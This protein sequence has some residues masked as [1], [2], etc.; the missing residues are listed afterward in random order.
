[1][2]ILVTGGTGF[3]GSHT[4]VELQ[5]KGYEVIIV[6]N[7]SNSSADIADKIGEIS[8]VVPVLEVFDLTDKKLTGDFFK[9]NSDI[10]GIIHFAAYKAVG[11][12]VQ[13]PLM[14]YGNNLESLMNILQGM[15][16]GQPST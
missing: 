5:A 8:G 13:N 3:I 2:K 15:K 6:D 12:S 11:E 7:L 9:R 10:A 16:D 14:Y 4:V 1:M